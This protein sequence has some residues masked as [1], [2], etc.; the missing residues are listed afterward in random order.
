[1]IKTLLVL[2]TLSTL[3]SLANPVYALTNQ[4]SYTTTYAVQDTSAAD[5]D[6]L[7]TDNGNLIRATDSYSAKLFGVVQ[8]LPV[9]VYRNGDPAKLAVARDGLATVNITTFN[10]EIKK[11]DY[12]TSS[13]IQGKGQKAT[14]S[15]YILGTAN[16][17]FGN[18]DGTQLNYNGK[19][20]ASGQIQVNVRIEYAEINTS[21][22]LPRLLD[23]FNAALFKNLQ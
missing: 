12:I 9:V 4:Q 18:T 21:R 7:F 22:G 19:S 13:E 5:G 16:E 15:G 1:M 14:Q 8:K 2:A 20:Y 3:T 17:D 6:I 10:G 23:Y 11:G